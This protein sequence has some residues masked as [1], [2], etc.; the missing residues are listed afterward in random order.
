MK[1]LDKAHHF[2]YSLGLA[3]LAG[4]FVGPGWG[5]V[6]AALLGLAKEAWDG[7]R[8]R[9][10]WWDLAANVVGLLAAWVVIG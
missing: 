10:D 2:F 6:I 4:L 7:T 9:W 5:L 8:G 3:V 1:H